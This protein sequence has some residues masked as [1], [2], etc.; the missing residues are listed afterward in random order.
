MG[1][2]HL[3]LP[4]SLLNSPYGNILI[5]KL[6]LVF[7]MGLLGGYHHFRLHKLINKKIWIQINRQLQKL[8]IFEK[9]L[10][11]EF[12]FGIGVIFTS[13]FLTITSP[14]QQD[15][16]HNMDMVTL[17]Y[18]EQSDSTKTTN[19]QNHLFDQFFSFI[20]LLL[21]IS[22]ALSVILFAR[23]GWLNLKIYNQNYQNNF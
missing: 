12:I 2:L 15:N 21:S 13:S 17:P 9:S 6:L 10:K 1:L 20:T 22:I 14:P 4:T 19:N 5:V 16:F 3:Q 23:Q 7:P 18:S 11:L 8:K